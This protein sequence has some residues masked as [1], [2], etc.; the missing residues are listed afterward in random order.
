MNRK[1]IT[2]YW[3]GIVF[4]M[5]VLVG[6][7]SAVTYL[8]SNGVFD[9]SVIYVNDM[10]LPYS[11]I[12]G[13]ENNVNS[14][15]KYNIEVIYIK[16]NL[17][18]ESKTLNCAGSCETKIEFRRVFFGDYKVLITAKHDGKNYRK[19]LTFTLNKPETSFK[20]NIDPIIFYENVNSSL[21]V[22]GELFIRNSAIDTFIVE[23]FPKN[24]TEFK[25]TFDL[26]CSKN[27]CD[28][29]FAMD[30]QIFFGDYTMNVYSP[31]DTD[32]YKFK[33]VY[34]DDN[35]SLYVTNESF[36]N[37]TDYTLYDSQ[38][39][40]VNANVNLK[41]KGKVVDNFDLY[42]KKVVKKEKHDIEFNFNS[43]KVKSIK[44]KDV[45]LDDV[46]I[47]FEEVPVEKV[48]LLN[49]VSHAFAIDPHL[50]PEV[51]S[52]DITFVA[53]GWAVLKCADYNFSSQTCFGDYVK[54]LD[55]IPGE[56]YTISLTPTDPII[57]Q[58]NDYI[59]SPT[60]ASCQDNSNGWA[61]GNCDDISYIGSKLCSS[62][63]GE[64][65]YCNDNYNESHGGLR[66]Q[67]AGSRMFFKDI[68]QDKCEVI[69]KVEVIYNVWWSDLTKPTRTLSIDADGDGWTSISF[70][71]DGTPPATDRVVD[72]TNSL[73][74]GEYWNCSDFFSD[75]ATAG[76]QAL[77]TIAGGGSPSTVYTVYAD[78]LVYRVSYN[79]TQYAL[80]TNK[81]S[82]FQGETVFITGADLWNSNANVSVNLTLPNSTVIDL[83]KHLSNSS[84]EFNLSYVLGSYATVA[85]NYTLFAMQDNDS[86]KNATKFFSVTL[87]TPT[88]IP[89]RNYFSVGETIYFT[90]SSFIKNDAVNI[91]YRFPSGTLSP[92]FSDNLTTNSNGAFSYSWIAPNDLVTE[93][94][95]FVFNFSEDMNPSY[96]GTAT[97]TYV[98]RPNGSSTNL[99]DINASDGTSY[100]L[101][102]SGGTQNLDVSFPEV[103]PAS[104]TTLDSYFAK[105]E[106]STVGA[107]SRTLQW[108]ND[109]SLGYQTICTIPNSASKTI[110]SCNLTSYAKYLNDYNSMNIRLQETGGPT[111]NW[112]IDFVFIEREFLV[113]PPTVTLIDPANDTWYDS[114][115]IITFTYNVTSTFFNM[116]SCKFY[117]DGSLNQTNNSITNDV[118]QTFTLQSVLPEGAHTWQVGC[119]EDSTKLQQGNS[120]IFDFYIDLTKPEVN[121]TTPATGTPTNVVTNTFSGSFGDNLGLANATLQVWNSTGSLIGTNFT[122]LSGTS[123]TASLDVTV[124]TD[125]TYY[126]NYLVYDRAG[127]FNNSA[128]NY[129][130]LVDLTKP[131]VD[132]STPANDT[133][134]NGLFQSFTGNFSDSFTGLKNATL[135]VWNSTGGLI[136]TNS[137]LISGSSNSTTR[138]FTFPGEGTYYWNYL[139]YDVAGNSDFNENNFTFIV[140]L[141]KPV[142]EL[143]SPANGSPSGLFQSFTGNFTDPLAGLK[144]AT[145]M[146]WNSTDGLVGTNFSLVSGTSNS[147]TLGF[148]FS[149][150]GVYYWNYKVYDMA[151]NFNF[152]NTNFTLFV[153]TSAPVVELITPVNNTPTNSLTIDFTGNFSDAI[154]GLANATLMIWNSTGGLVGTNFSLVSGTSNS[155]TLGFT[156]PGEGTYY[157]NYLVYDTVGNFGMNN[158][159][160]TIRIDLTK[161]DVD[162]ILPFNGSWSNFFESFTGN[163]SDSFTGLKNATLM[164][165][166]ST[167][168]LVGTNFSLVSGTS[169]STTLGFTFTYEDTYYWNYKVYD[170]AGNFEMNNT[171][172]THYV[173]LT[174]P[175]VQLIS[176]ANDTPF[177]DTRVYFVA[178]FTD[179]VKLGNA[180]LMIWN[181]TGGL[182]GTNFTTISGT[183]N[184][185]NLSFVFPA[186]GVYY[187][188]YLVYDFVGNFNYS[189]VNRTVL[190][191]TTP[192]K[193]SFIPPSDGNDSW[194][195]RHWTMINVSVMDMTFNSTWLVWNGSGSGNLACNFVSGWN[196]T[197]FINKSMVLNGLYN[198]KV[199]GNDTFNNQNCSVTRTIHIN[200]T[201]PEITVVS[202]LNSTRFIE[203]ETILF[204]ITTL[205]PANSSWMEF[206]SNGT[207]YNLTNITFSNWIKYHANLS[208]GWHDVDF[209][210]DDFVGNI[211]NAAIRILILP[212]KNIEVRK[213]ILAI[214][215]SRYSVILNITNQGRWKDFVLYDFVDN[216][217]MP[218]NFS[219]AYTSNSSVAG[220]YT[221]DVLRWNVTLNQSDS[222]LVSYFVNGT[223]DFNLMYNYMCGVD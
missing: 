65:T 73:P 54:I 118:N 82:Y 149:S 120:S 52:Y 220:S 41:K 68:S 143:I 140:D 92:S 83:G 178:N 165:W 119:V 38:G 98:F 70:T 197:C 153:D 23:I 28:F 193:I 42:Q 142:V 21:H 46:N 58:I 1:R 31:V 194:V 177:N 19:R 166:N 135:M 100:N 13:L 112:Y 204:N 218:Y 48:N 66:S 139:V 22:K 87:R 202:P 199:C 206:D 123:D 191:D 128:S 67:V 107:V 192:P 56:E 182:V 203:T 63:S 173:D 33:V 12:I 205:I 134:I 25:K 147:T 207:L 138:G 6:T 167:G 141:S 51:E 47:G 26:T 4:F 74:G 110:Y 11:V 40:F 113:N 62:G 171:N 158:T 111:D 97:I 106:Y 64:Y 55:T 124:P 115:S 114:Q 127:N 183:S 109:T 34:I 30:S 102:G 160:F 148:T 214:S 162:L 122:T 156:F 78:T 155:T 201:I 184:S 170:M 187:W 77:W 59:L 181:S 14:E 36:A 137:S 221:G 90:G 96:Y 150:D 117:L 95:G 99:A 5:L 172:F 37:L 130:L 159:N 35:K 27:P 49:T 10:K 151:G 7:I 169:N 88:V 146:I 125:G 43:G 126:W 189:G 84:G 131:N 103:L 3:T 211:A 93:T 213:S 80:E 175:N 210:A 196:Y 72:V 157:W 85:S 57:A 136:G 29:D 53:T 219:I 32:Q 186:D 61:S 188:N 129:T 94:G 190:I 145:L 217:F 208:I 71:N 168:S 9:A 116:S 176:P 20:V 75:S 45:F 101:G 212:D 39:R 89:G 179:I 132:L 79:Y 86:T 105:V 180:T 223:G 44:I 69:T 185:S 222:M 18:V 161:P 195:P 215:S 174:K 121:L 133:S 163:F 164:V 50:P 198:Y 154:A 152:N 17:V 108:Y 144:N 81:N 2:E 104:G 209:Y 8:N 76:I 216:E 60:S 15:L 200:K 24:N 16:E 91:S